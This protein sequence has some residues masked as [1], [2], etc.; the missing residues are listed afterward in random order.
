M[1]RSVLIT[2][3]KGGVGKSTVSAN[4]AHAMAELFEPTV[5]C[6]KNDLSDLT[7]INKKI[8]LIDCDFGVRSLDLI[9]GVEDTNIYDLNDVLEKKVTL[10][11]AVRA[12]DGR[13]NLFVVAAPMNYVSS[14]FPVDEFVKLVEEAKSQYEFVILDSAPA[15]AESFY[16]AQKAADMSLIVSSSTSCSLRAAAK[17][18]SE[19]A[20]LGSDEPKLVMNMFEPRKILSKEYS[21]IMK[22]IESASSQLIGIIPFDSAVSV[23]QEKGKSCDLKRDKCGKAFIELAYRVIGFNVP[24]PKRILGIST[25]RL[26]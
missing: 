14:E 26:F 15:H 17:T 9:M 23:K 20:K 5:T 4:L 2:S 6:S 19:L 25:K 3:C 12:V 16:I 1:G 11:E 10:D 13:E 22:S 24:L 18:A 21:G 7:A 8:L